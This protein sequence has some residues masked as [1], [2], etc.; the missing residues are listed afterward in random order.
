MKKFLAERK[1][2][3]SKIILGWLVNIRTL[4]ISLPMAE[5]TKCSN[6]ISSLLSS[7]RVS[8][9]QLE[10]LI[11]RLDHTATILHML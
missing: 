1:M 4:S 11:G 7:S 6:D 3:E 9:K 10:G 2:T 8:H 5:Y